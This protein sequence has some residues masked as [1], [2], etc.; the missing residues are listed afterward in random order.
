[1]TSA[2]AAQGVW[3]GGAFLA[4]ANGVNPASLRAYEAWHSFEHVPERLT[5][6]G[7]L[8]GKRYVAGRGAAIRYLTIY[9]LDDASA[10]ESAAYR[11]LLAHP[12]PASLAMRPAMTDFRR[13]LYRHR[14]QSGSGLARHLGWL[15]W[16]GA[17]PDGLPGLAGRDSIVS[18]RLGISTI[19]APHP[20]FPASPGDGVA[21]QIALL[22]GT[23]RRA[24][25]RVLKRIAR[26][27]EVGGNVIEQS[28]FD[29]VLAY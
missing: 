29:L 15:T 25:A 4:V 7:F 24:L 27:P 23:E 20:A 18:V 26:T 21:H 10:V 5:M 28:V 22:G 11:H 3:R 14:G 8:A 13:E 9:D 16:H 6:P 2:V 19:V 12:T 17:E 1:M